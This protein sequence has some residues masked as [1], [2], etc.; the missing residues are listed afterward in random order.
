[1]QLLSIP[2]CFLQGQRANFS[3]RLPAACRL[4]RQAGTTG[5]LC[6]VI[7]RTRM[8]LN[9]K[10]LRI[11]FLIITRFNHHEPIGTIAHQV[12]PGSATE[13][14]NGWRTGLSPWLKLGDTAVLFTHLR[15]STRRFALL[16][17]PGLL[18]CG[19]ESFEMH[20]GPMGL[21][22]V[23]LFIGTASIIRSQ[24]T[25]LVAGEHQ[26]E[27]HPSHR[28]QQKPALWPRKKTAPQCL[29]CPTRHPAL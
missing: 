20:T 11:G 22:A 29:R 24:R 5:R 16:F 15:L 7:N 21:A 9:C 18:C 12:P 28:G 26:P 25:G 6:G 13:Q 3:P 23:V 17:T 4:S 2:G 27:A 10:G 14:F 8:S 1:M 19:H